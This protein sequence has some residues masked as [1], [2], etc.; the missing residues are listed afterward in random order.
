MKL[1]QL[2]LKAVF[3]FML[4]AALPSA[5]VYQLRDFRRTVEPFEQATGRPIRGS[6]DGMSEFLGRFGL[7]H[8]YLGRSQLDNAQ[9]AAL[10]PRL[11][12]LPGLS[13]LDLSQTRITDAGL[14]ELYGLT[15]LRTL[16][17]YHN[18]VSASAVAKLQGALPDCR[19]LYQELSP[20]EVGAIKAIQRLG[21]SVTQVEVEGGAVAVD[22]ELSRTQ[23]TDADLPAIIGAIQAFSQVRAI[24]VR[25][26]GFSPAGLAQLRSAFPQAQIAP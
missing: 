2:S 24:G 1:P 14:A 22:V 26:A 7:S 8:L 19:I 18:A 15:R 5:C 6:G 25:G 23:I 12:G 20:A 3:V 17:L 4:L 13:A 16:I 21:G 10:R 11:Q 9:L